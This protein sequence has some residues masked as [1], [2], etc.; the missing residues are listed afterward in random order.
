ME[1]CRGKGKLKCAFS[2]RRVSRFCLMVNG[3]PCVG[4]SAET[5]I[6][7]TVLGT[8][9]PQLGIGCGKNTE[10]VS[11]SRILFSAILLN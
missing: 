8:V 7:A 9:V 6:L 3:I 10:W 11:F 4:V 1:L 5:A 2:E